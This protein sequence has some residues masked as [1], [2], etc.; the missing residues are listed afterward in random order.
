MPARVIITDTAAIRDSASGDAVVDDA[1][2]DI[3]LSASSLMVANAAMMVG[4]S[5]G[6]AAAAAAELCDRAA[7]ACLAIMKTRCADD[8]R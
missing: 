1:S 6:D 8:N 3:A 5:T 4:Q 7:G 2:A